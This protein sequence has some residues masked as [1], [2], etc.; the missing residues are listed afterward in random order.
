LGRRAETGQT[1]MHVPHPT[2]FDWSKSARIVIFFISVSLGIDLEPQ[3]IRNLLPCVHREPDVLWHHLLAHPWSGYY[4]MRGK[5]VNLVPQCGRNQ[6]YHRPFE[7]K[8]ESSLQYLAK[9]KSADIERS[10]LFG[11]RYLIIITKW[12]CQGRESFALNPTECLSSNASSLLWLI[13]IGDSI[14]RQV[15]TRCLPPSLSVIP[16]QACD[17]PSEGLKCGLSMLTKSENRCCPPPS[18]EASTMTQAGGPGC[19]YWDSKT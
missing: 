6:L 19:R 16:N 5:I 1:W 7:N 15:E 12:D 17:H 4:C 10:L 3:N 8:T 14:F 9:N 11:F 2:H 18:A 13:L